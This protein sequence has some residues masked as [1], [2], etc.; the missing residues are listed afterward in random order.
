[1][2]LGQPLAK[3]SLFGAVDSDVGL[4]LC[5]HCW[6]VAL[7]AV[8]LWLLSNAALHV[9]CSRNIFG[10]VDLLYL[11]VDSRLRPLL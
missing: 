7:C 1:M 11:A 4:L 2:L 3:L 9:A 10:M 6:G 5:L 8:A